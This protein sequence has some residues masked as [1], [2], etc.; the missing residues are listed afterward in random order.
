MASPK[1]SLII[2]GYSAEYSQTHPSPAQRNCGMQNEMK[3]SETKAEDPF[4]GLLSPERWLVRVQK[5]G[6]SLDWKFHKMIRAEW[7]TMKNDLHWEIPTNGSRATNRVNSKYSDFMAPSSSVFLFFLLGWTN[8]PS[9]HN[10]TLSKPWRWAT[11]K[12]SK[13]LLDW[14][15]NSYLLSPIS[16]IPEEEEVQW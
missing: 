6:N 8:S 12:M 4:Y 13:V 16:A 10:F 11:L 9:F 14:F 15:G 2:S 7:V 3:W 5:L 1:P